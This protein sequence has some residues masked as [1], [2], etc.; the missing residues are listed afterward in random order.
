[1]NKERM[2]KIVEL[3]ENLP[4]NKFNMERWIANPKIDTKPQEEKLQIIKDT[5]GL[6]YEPFDCGTSACIAG[7]TVMFMNDFKPIDNSDYMHETINRRAANWLELSD[8]EMEL[9]FY[10]GSDSLWGVLT[11][12]Y[13][14]ELNFDLEDSF[15]KM[16]SKQAAKGLRFVLENNIDLDN[17]YR[18]DYE[19]LE[20]HYYDSK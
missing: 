19:Q 18:Y 3:L 6:F 20:E 11:M 15:G 14:M 7:W 16:T 2:L 4:D 9:I 8:K 12:E 10:L 17:V 1:M 13:Y 5:G